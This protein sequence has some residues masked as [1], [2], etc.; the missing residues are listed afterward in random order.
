LTGLG[1]SGREG[2]DV[3]DPDCAGDVDGE[4]R[5]II[6][7]R[8]AGA[9]VRERADF[10]ADRRLFILPFASSAKSRCPRLM[11]LIAFLP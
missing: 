10:L 4:V 6:G 7:S 8:R 5:N 1:A 9:M 11:D 3:T 2:V